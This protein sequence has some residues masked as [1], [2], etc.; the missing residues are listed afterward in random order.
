VNQTHFNLLTGGK[1]RPTAITHNL[2]RHEGIVHYTIF[3][4]ESLE[5]LKLHIPHRRP[6]FTIKPGKAWSREAHQH[7]N[8][9]DFGP[10]FRSNKR[11]IT[12]ELFKIDSQITALDSERSAMQDLMQQAQVQMLD[13]VA[14]W[15]NE[16]VNQKQELAKD[17]LPMVLHTA[18]KRSSLNRPRRR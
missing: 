2:E 17:C 8:L 18:R 15:K 16:T 12:E 6:Q 10:R 9:T 11:S 13:L 1:V 4:G 5:G 3:S 14:A 7:Q